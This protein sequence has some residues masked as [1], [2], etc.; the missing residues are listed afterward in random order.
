[1]RGTELPPLPSDRSFGFTFAA[2]FGLVGA[3]MLWRSNEYFVAAM[4]IAATFLVVALALSRL[5]HPL[6][7]AWMRLAAL[8]NRI[9]SPIVM[10]AIYFVVL[11]P[12]AVAM[13]LRGRDE[14]R[15]RFESGLSTYWIKRDPPG[16]DGST[17]PRQF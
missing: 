16:P 7:F 1:M 3:W 8:L 15:R 9:V 14:L 2:A 17:F 11:T 6:N 13:R 5:L 12:V 4:A 10:G